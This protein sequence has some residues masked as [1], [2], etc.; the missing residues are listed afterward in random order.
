MN[1]KIAVFLK[2][3]PIDGLNK[4]MKKP[5]V[6][7]AKVVD[8]EFIVDTAEGSMKGKAGDY[9]VRGIDGEIYPCDKEIF[10]KHNYLWTPECGFVY[11]E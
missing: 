3:F 9:L 11:G 1:E 7:H 4:Y 5:L 10:E 6:I 2:E 8:T